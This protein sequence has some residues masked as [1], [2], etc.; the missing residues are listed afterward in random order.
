MEYSHQRS[1]CCT[2]HDLS[3][4]VWLI[5]NFSGVTPLHK[6]S[7]PIAMLYSKETT[8]KR[9]V[10]VTDVSPLLNSGFSG[11]GTQSGMESRVGWSCLL[12]A[13]VPVSCGGLV[14]AW[15]P[16]C[17]SSCE[18]RLLKGSQLPPLPKNYPQPEAYAPHQQPTAKDWHNKEDQLYSYSRTPKGSGG[19]Y[20]AAETISF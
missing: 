6:E 16:P 19:C 13:S 5:R 20:P 11:D 14:P 3:A 9:N 18:C 7:S 10:E 12:E 17:P 8:D 4:K 2:E 1:N 15:I